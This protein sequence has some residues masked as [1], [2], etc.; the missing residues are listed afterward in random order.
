[1]APCGDCN[2]DLVPSSEPLQIKAS[3]LELDQ[4]KGPLQI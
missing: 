1:M 3:L 2:T 4:G